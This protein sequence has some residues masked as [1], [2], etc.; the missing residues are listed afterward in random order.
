M[1]LRRAGNAETCFQFRHSTETGRR[2][3]ILRT[4][5]SDSTDLINI[6]LT[7]ARIFNP[8]ARSVVNSYIAL[9]SFVFLFH[10]LPVLKFIVIITVV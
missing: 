6:M 7:E 8:W 1:T 10:F 5:Q 3:L 4:I 9:R 2:S